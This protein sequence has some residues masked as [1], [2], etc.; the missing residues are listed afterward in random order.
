M[1]RVY[2]IKPVGMDGPIKIG[3]SSHPDGRRRNL[4]TWSPFALEITAS[5][6]G[7]HTL[8]RRFHARFLSSHERREWFRASPELVETI[9]QINAGQFDISQLPD[10]LF[11]ANFTDGKSRKRDP[12][13]GR[14]MSYSN[15]VGALV[16]RSGFSCPVDVSGMVKAGDQTRIDAVEAFL[17][18]PIRHGLADNE[19]AVDRRAAFIASRAA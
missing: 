13:F 7:D 16:R 19:W 18:D 6:E 17:R 15:R 1:K 9:E 11:V 12:W 3:C 14:Q 10:P 5:I 8:E 2:F 4:D